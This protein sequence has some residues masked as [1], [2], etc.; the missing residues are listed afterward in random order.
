MNLHTHHTPCAV[1]AG[2]VCSSFQL[3]SPA[4]RATSAPRVLVLL[5]KFRTRGPLTSPFTLPRFVSV[6]L[7]L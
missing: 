2:G 7:S 5:R 1:A 3:G 6:G 4:R